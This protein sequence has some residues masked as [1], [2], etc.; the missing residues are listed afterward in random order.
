MTDEETRVLHYASALW[1]CAPELIEIGVST[2]Q[3]GVLGVVVSAR[4]CPPE[5]RGGRWGMQGGFFY[6]TD[7]HVEQ[8]SSG[9]PTPTLALKWLNGRRRPRVEE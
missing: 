8:V 7:E 3:E 6:V 9:S 2:A 4:V 5:E 1:D